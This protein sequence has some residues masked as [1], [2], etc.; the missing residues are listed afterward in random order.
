MKIIMIKT[1]WPEGESFIM[2]R[3]RIGDEYIFL[4]IITEMYAVLDGKKVLLPAG[5]CIYFP[6][7]SYQCISS[8]PGGLLH[9]WAHFS[10]EFGDIAEKFGFKPLTPYTAADSSFVTEIMRAAE[11]EFMNGDEFSDEICK[12]RISELVAKIVRAN[13]STLRENVPSKLHTAFIEARARIHMEYSR[14]WDIDSM[15]ELVH[16]SPS[17]FFALYKSLFGI[18]PK[19]DLVAVRME[20]AK[21]LMENGDVSVQDAAEI[22]GYTNVYHFI[23][24]FKQHTGTT[25]GKYKNQLKQI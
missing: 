19:S 22:A 7:G 23:R 20:H 12:Y 17:R 25:P 4:H 11:L 14:Q 8:A 6:P 5:S 21:I 24:S 1:L 15:A 18:S 16:L 9:D 13:H 2:E 3:K 10:T